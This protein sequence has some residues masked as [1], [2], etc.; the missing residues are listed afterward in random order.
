[1]T[2]LP[3]G[4]TFAAP[5]TLATAVHAARLARLLSPLILPLAL[6][7]SAADAHAELGSTPPATGS[8]MNNAAQQSLLNGALRMRTLI[9]AGNTT[10]NEYAAS[11]GQIVAYTWQGPTMP[12]L[13]ALL[14]KYLDSY[15]AAAP[16]RF[17][18]AAP[19][20]APADDAELH[21]S[22]RVRPDVIVESGGTMRG[23][24]GRA[25]LPGALPP[26]VSIDDLQ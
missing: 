2:T 12:D 9:D 26:G 18:Q 21:A 8:A 16:E 14:G 6:A 15:R 1:M 4:P 5:A 3:S 10:I 11:D 17:D 13:S 20:D 23:Y 19:S 25:W 22:R 24:V 7:L